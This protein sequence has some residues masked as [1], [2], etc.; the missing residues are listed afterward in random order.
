[1]KK[2][3]LFF[4]IFFISISICNGQKTKFVGCFKWISHYYIGDF[5]KICFYND[6]TFF[7]QRHQNDVLPD[8]YSKG[9]WKTVSDTI[10]L[11]T[12]EPFL[13]DSLIMQNGNPLKDSIFIKIVDI[14]TGKSLPYRRFEIYDLN[15]KKMLI[16][17]TDSIGLL[18]LKINSE[19]KYLR[20]LEFLNYN[21]ALLKFS[22]F[23]NE[24]IVIKMD[25]N[26]D[27]MKFEYV[28]DM[29]FLLKSKKKLMEIYGKSKDII[30]Y[31]M[32]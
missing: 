10:K 15:L 28:T 11:I 32:K 13:S 2:R 26:H 24:H 18:K 5:Q 17:N 14:N 12:I 31:R 7:Y 4:I 19:Y 21:T 16:I 3:Q 25:I 1:M 9:I 29:S 27:P 20:I 22:S 8:T 30:Y 23:V 6:S